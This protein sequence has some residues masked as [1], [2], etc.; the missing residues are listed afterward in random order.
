MGFEGSGKLRTVARFHDEDQVCPSQELRS[1]WRVG[2]RSEAR[3]CGL[4]ASLAQPTRLG[5]T[6]LYM[7]VE[8]AGQLG[9][10]GRRQEVAASSDR[11]QT[12]VRN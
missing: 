11:L 4:D 10:I 7:N 1:H 9:W 3:S 2:I 6:R 12:G 8:Q 5:Q